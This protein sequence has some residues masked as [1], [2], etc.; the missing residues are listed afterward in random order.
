VFFQFAIIGQRYIRFLVDGFVNMDKMIGSSPEFQRVVR[1]AQMVSATD[2]PILILGEKGAGK[3]RL[4][5]EIHSWGR[6]SDKPFVAI[7]CTGAEVDQFSLRHNREEIGT[8]FLDEVDE[9]SL[10]AQAKLLAALE[11]MWA[12]GHAETQCRVVASSALD[13]AE[14]V[15]DGEFRQDLYFKIHVVPLTIPPL[16]ERRDDIA[17]LVKQFTQ[18]LAKYH[19]RKPPRYSVT[20]K[21]LM[22]QYDWPGNI[23]ELHNL[24]ERMVILMAGAMIQ[25]ENMPLELRQAKVLEQAPLFSLPDS[26]VDLVALEGNIIQQAVS[27]SGGNR[28]K[29]ARLL[30]LTRDTLLYRIQKH[31]I[32]L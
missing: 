7:R 29:A 25:P 31:G 24:C 30:G 10:E 26:G 23:Q 22:R 18:T 15:R 9:L 28:S 11:E 20:A 21:T 32:T 16:R 8:I 13:L 2:A 17:I 5:R 1:A 14:Q 27:M 19:G 6:N 3:E 12:H 4:A